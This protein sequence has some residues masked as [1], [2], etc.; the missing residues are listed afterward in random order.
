M[1]FFDCPE[2]WET[3][4]RC[5]YMYRNWTKE[6]RQELAIAAMK[7]VPSEQ[8]YYGDTMPD[9][10][11]NMSD[12]DLE[13]TL[14]V[15]NDTSLTL[16]DGDGFIG[17]N[18]P[19]VGIYVQRNRPQKATDSPL[20][21]YEEVIHDLCDHIRILERKAAEAQSLCNRWMKTA[22]DMAPGCTVGM[23][24]LPNNPEAFAMSRA[25]V[26][27]QLERQLSEARQKGIEECA[28]LSWIL[29]MDYCRTLRVSPG[30]KPQSQLF[31][32]PDA[33]R[34]LLKEKP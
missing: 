8:E 25:S 26:I 5:G 32:L 1:S 3:P 22:L 15:T 11:D 24:I 6:Q 31:A 13:K 30:D 12:T 23:V 4:C 18:R 28:Q 7:S 33:L 16:F 9:V 2:C 10:N 14:S 21:G 17:I 19:S 27:H 20:S 29:L 34:A